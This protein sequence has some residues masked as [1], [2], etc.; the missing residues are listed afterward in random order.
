M[1][2]TGE[3][4]GAGSD[5]PLEGR[6]GPARHPGLALVVISLTQLIVVLDAAI[7]NVALP[8]I[9]RALHFS[10]ADLIWVINGYTLAFGGL[11]LL[12]GRTG[13]LFGRRRMFLFGVGLF[14]AA[15]FLGGLAT[16]EAWLIGARVLQG[17]GG[18]VAAP[19]ALALIAS[20]FPEGAA[21][22]RAMGVYAA[23][24]GG[25]AAIGVLLGGAL[26]SSLGWRWVLF[27]NVPIGLA[28]VATTPF[29]IAET[30]MR[31]GKM[32]IPG[33]LTSTVGMTLLVYG[34]IHAATTSWG[35]P[36]T[37]T[38]IAVGCVLLTVFVA[39]EAR[40]RH[41]LMPLHLFRSRSRASVY[42]IT[43]AI[44]L[45]MFAITYFLTLFMQDVLG[46]GPMRAG[47]A[48]LPF[49]LVI[50][51]VAGATA[52][53]V[54]RYGIKVPLVLG[55]ALGAL[56]LLWFAQ[57]TPA[58]GYVGSLLGPMLVTGA[59]VAMCFVPLTLGAV[60]GVHSDEQGIASALLNSGQQVGGSL[61]LA[62]LGTIAV[63]TTRNQIG[64]FLASLGPKAAAASRY[65][66][67][68]P[69]PNSAPIPPVIHHGIT[70]A[71]VAGYTTAFAIGSGILA[72][73]FLIAL[74]GVP[75][76]GGGE[77]AVQPPEM[78]LDVT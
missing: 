30:E 72:A 27:V 15:S 49:A 11:L 57:V 26:T 29:V 68:A 40:S 18:A 75:R 59:G 24:S 70:S 64:N 22:N 12:G 10:E 76:Q 58:S 2:E 25:G 1:T 31:R 20:T 32:D 23:M 8:S 50:V 7:V 39:I 38:T 67:P 78:A 43:L 48:Y 71:F 56:G 77:L 52:R 9:Q 60:S 55:T 4:T 53:V 5:A 63:A 37:V 16:S 28:I 46:Y 21:R 74:V 54:S 36:V 42:G 69:P 44:G 66:G 62:V 19:T 6:A 65:V 17:V 34:L 33:A 14:T 3:R 73:A 41:A 47:V 61:G 13:D 51:A 45:S 35:S